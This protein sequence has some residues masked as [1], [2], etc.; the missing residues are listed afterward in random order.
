MSV[1]LAY[2]MN[3]VPATYLQSI[4]LPVLYRFFPFSDISP[5]IASGKRVLKDTG[6]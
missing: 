4:F 5:P 2:K 6:A 1:T 3:K